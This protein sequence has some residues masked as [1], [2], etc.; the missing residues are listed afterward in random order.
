MNYEGAFHSLKTASN[1][2]KPLN[3]QQL[4]SRANEAAW[5]CAECHES[6]GNHP[7]HKLGWLQ[8]RGLHS[9]WQRI[10]KLACGKF[11]HCGSKLGSI[12]ASG[13]MLVIVI[14]WET[15]HKLFHSSWQ[16]YSWFCFQR[17][18]KKTTSCGWFQEEKMLRTL[19]LVCWWHHFIFQRSLIVFS[20]EGSKKC[21]DCWCEVPSSVLLLLL[22]FFSPFLPLISLLASLPI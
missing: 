21:R 11:G 16:T 6:L 3:P 2:P 7:W 14:L 9:L 18:L 19:L 17:D 10:Q 8:G 12:D 1:A 5:G 22:F 4:H 20:A 13:K 15:W